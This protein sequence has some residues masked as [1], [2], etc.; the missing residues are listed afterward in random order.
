M[1]KNTW[2]ISKTAWVLLLLIGLYVAG[3]SQ[4]AR[5]VTPWVTGDVFVGVS[6]GSYQVYDNTGVFKETISDGLGGFTT[7]CAFNLSLDKLYTTNFSNAQVV[8]YNDP[9]PHSIAQFI[10]TG[11]SPTESVVFASNGHFFVG[12]PINPDIEEYDAAGNLIDTDTVAADGTGGPDWIDLAADQAT[13]FFASEGRDIRR[14]DVVNDVQL[15]NFATLPGV[16]NAFALRLLPPGDGSGGLLVAD[17]LEVKRLDG[18]G[19][20]VQTYDVAG[21][22][23]WFALNLDPNGTSFWSG[24]FGTANF[25]RFNIAS[26]AVEVGPI[27]TGTGPSTLFGICLKGELTA[28][29]PKEG[30]MTGGGSVFQGSRVTHGFQLHCDASQGPNNLEVNWNGNRF[31]LETLTSAA[32]SD[33]PNI[34]EAPPVA[35]FDTYKGEGTGRYNGV[36]GA[37]AAWTFTDAGEPGGGDFAEIVI[38]DANGNNVLT[39]SGFLNRGNHQAHKE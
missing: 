29:Q 39:V 4:P 30:R 3:T 24:N 10:S 6:G 34:D 25:Y 26:G 12:G 22:D 9:S 2:R 18:A 28:A 15:P 21:E 33:A 38:T 5:A 19:N 1:K 37:T 8:V 17:G 35:G 36:S 14:F 7:G 23:S 16:G 32:C 20:V 27:N 31:H 11:R 13:M